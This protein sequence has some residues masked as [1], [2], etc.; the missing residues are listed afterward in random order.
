MNIYGDIILL[1]NTIHI[2]V[3]AM[4]AGGEKSYSRL[5]P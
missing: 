2:P 1:T 3:R 4:N 5:L